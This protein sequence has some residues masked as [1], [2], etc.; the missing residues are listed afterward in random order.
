[1]NFLSIYTIACGAFWSVQEIHKRGVVEDNVTHAIAL[2]YIKFKERV[3]R[4]EVDADITRLQT[5]H[6]LNNL[7]VIDQIVIMLLKIIHT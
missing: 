7:D 5:E 3:E 1:M 6:S 4:A 2:I